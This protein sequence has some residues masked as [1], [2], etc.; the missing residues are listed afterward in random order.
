M[1]HKVCFNK[2]PAKGK[3]KSIKKA[4]MVKLS[5]QN[6]KLRSGTFSSALLLSNSNKFSVFLCL[7]H[8][9]LREG[10]VSSDPS[11]RCLVKWGCK[12]PQCIYSCCKSN[13]S[14]VFPQTYLKY[15]YVSE[16]APM[17]VQ[18][19]SAEGKVMD[20]AGRDGDAVLLQFPAPIGLLGQANDDP[21][22]MVSFG[23]TRD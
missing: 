20:K 18:G 5:G 3:V 17:E 21:D 4:G 23:A 10:T 6:T 15:S 16:H 14:P 2:M 9:V 13:N 19:K 1:D 8:T 12:I 11:V 22:P 7:I